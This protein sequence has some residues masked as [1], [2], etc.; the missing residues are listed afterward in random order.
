MGEAGIFSPLS[1][2]EQL[3]AWVEANLQLK[4]PPKGICPGHCSPLEYLR[5][6]YFDQVDLVVWAPR[7]GGKTRMGAAATL[8]DLLHKPPCSVRIL[9]GSLDQSLRMW[10]HLYPD[11]ARLAEASIEG[12]SLARRIQLDNGSSAAV[13]TQSQRAVRGLHV[14]KMRCDEVE[15][16]HPAVWEA[17]QLV[18]RSIGTE[19]GRRIAGVIEA[20]S[21]LHRPWGLMQKI[22]D[23]A[24]KNGTRILKWCLIDVLARCPSEQPCA[25]CGLADE[26]HGVAHERCDGFFEIDD[27][28]AMKRRVSRETWEAEMLCRRPAVHD[29]VF[30]AFSQAVHVRE[31]L[32]GSFADSEATL[33]LGIDFGFTAPFVCL[34]IRSYPD[35]TAHV[36]DE[37]VQARQTLRHHIQAIETRGWAKPH[38]VACDPAGRGKNDQTGKSNVQLLRNAGY[39]VRSRASHICDGLE[40]IRTAL[41]PALGRPRLYIHPQCRNLIM[42]LVAYHYSQGGG[43]TPEKDGQHDHLIDALRYF[44]IVRQGGGPARG[45]KP[46]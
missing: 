37:Y 18:T 11:L 30:P 39:T 2:L 16:F 27:A 38:I 23:A 12:R 20:I 25:G 28:I 35:Q 1:S 7:G 17:T 22:I 32:D 3:R 14:Q 8:L 9:G 40:L 31:R 19:D 15:L 24:E 26:C 42:A 46:Y 44:Y 41:D 45:G 4:L 10:D 29:A 33:W 6:A 36:V 43:E 21:T 13:L 5:S 34:W